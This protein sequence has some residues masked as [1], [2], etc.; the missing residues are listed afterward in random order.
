MSIFSRII[1]KRIAAYQRD[2]IELHYR[3]VD[4]MYGQ[5]RG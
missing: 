3:E 5:M 1:D 4:N 2:L